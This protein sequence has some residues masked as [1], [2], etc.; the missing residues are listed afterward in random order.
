MCKSFVLDPARASWQ[1][2]TPRKP[3]WPVLDFT[4]ASWR[5]FSI[6]SPLSSTTEDLSVVIE[7]VFVNGSDDLTNDSLDIYGPGS[8]AIDAVDTVN[9]L[10]MASS[11]SRSV[12]P[13]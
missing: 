1:G 8:P 5:G 12:F 7:P 4:R 13:M 2:L 9:Y 11:S 6:A 10:P 3:F